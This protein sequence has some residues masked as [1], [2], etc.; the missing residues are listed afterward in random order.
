MN[1]IN[2]DKE[3]TTRD[4]TLDESGQLQ[5]NTDEEEDS[6]DC[7]SPGKRRKSESS[8]LSKSQKVEGNQENKEPGKNIAKNPN[9][10]DSES[11]SEELE[12]KE[13]T[14]SAR[15]EDERGTPKT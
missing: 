2:D 15:E 6:P 1:I 5:V 3:P 10:E 9:Y 11:D 7:Q 14:K 4:M 8:S 13:C 12:D